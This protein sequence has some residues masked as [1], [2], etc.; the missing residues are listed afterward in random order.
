MRRSVS[1]ANSGFGGDEKGA[2][3][4]DPPCNAESDLVGGFPHTAERLENILYSEP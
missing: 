1:R 3:T 2:L 4:L